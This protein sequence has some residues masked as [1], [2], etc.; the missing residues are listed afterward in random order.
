MTLPHKTLLSCLLCAGALFVTSCEEE[1]NENLQGNWYNTYSYFP[2]T[3]RGGAVCFQLRIGDELVAFVGTGANT[4]KTEEQ[5]RFRDFYAVR[6]SQTHR[7]EWTARFEKLYSVTDDSKASTTAKY[8]KEDATWQQAVRSMPNGLQDDGKTPLEDPDDPEK[9]LDAP[10]RNGAVGFAIGGKGYVGLGYDGVNFLND[11]WCYDPAENSWTKAPAYPGDG[12][13]YACC[14]VINDIAY[15]GGGEDYDNNILGDFYKFDG[16]NWEQVKTIGV[17]RAQAS[18]FAVGGKGYVFGGVNGSVID[19]F[20]RYDPAKDTWETLR[21]TA[22]KSR[23]SYDDQ[24]GSLS[25]YGATAFVLNPESFDNGGDNCRCYIA[26][27]GRG[28]IGQLTWEYNPYY[29]YWIQKTS[30][31]GNARKFAV[32]FVL[33]DDDDGLGKRQV[34]FVTTGGSS[35]MTIT[36]S[37]GQFYSDTWLF[38]PQAPWEPLD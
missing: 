26:T 10:A 9:V 24:Y 7:P 4:N 32:S 30:F 21:M 17:P 15:V 6:M 28:G 27:G 38:E 23:Q 34:P 20:Q 22:P 13:R 1:D 37:A 3:P 25:C 5:E 35:D 2:G 8:H 14:F 31:E 19:A 11:F 36:G 16:K 18:T 33:E 29:D 12:V